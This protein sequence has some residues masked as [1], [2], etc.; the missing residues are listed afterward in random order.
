MTRARAAARVV[1][2]LLLSLLSLP[3]G[4]ES[5]KRPSA[6]GGLRRITEAGWGAPACA[7]LTPSVALRDEK[8]KIDGPSR[9]YALAGTR[10][11]TTYEVKVSYAAT[12]PA[13][14]VV[15]VVDPDGS[16]TATTTTTTT[17]RG[18]DLRRRAHAR[19]LLNVEKVVIS[20]TTMRNLETRAG[21]VAVKV[22]A[23][24][25][26]PRGDGAK[27][28]RAEV[29]Y[30]VV[31][32]PTVLGGVVPAESVPV[33]VL[34]AMCV[35]VAVKFERLLREAVWGSD[36]AAPPVARKLSFE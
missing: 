23:G 1:A 26:K 18:G 12:N 10:P 33:I 8:V 32:S 15:E 27:A 21:G 20:S 22:S 16:A 13:D 31:L 19:Q 34:A 29:T 7:E 9:L 35:V 5:G 25:A 36:G 17:K 3:V 30:D 14:V 6:C 4:V 24:E 28:G 2:L 11:G